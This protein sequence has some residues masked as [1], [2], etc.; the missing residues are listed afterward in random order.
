[1]Y[2]KYKYFVVLSWNYILVIRPML[3]LFFLKHKAKE[4]PMLTAAVLVK[5]LV[6]VEKNSW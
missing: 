1:M 4:K 6:I 3:K 5:A 2:V